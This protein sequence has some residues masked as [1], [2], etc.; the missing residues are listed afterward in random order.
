MTG[1]TLYV[2]V[3]VESSHDH[4]VV[5]ISDI[6]WDNYVKDIKPQK[7]F[8]ARERTFLNEYFQRGVIWV[9][10]IVRVSIND[11]DDDPF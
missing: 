6:T 10:Y 4:D 9:G 3:W 5:P 2:Y 11:N 7:N 8:R 1:L